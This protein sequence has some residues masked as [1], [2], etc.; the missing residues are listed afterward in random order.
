MNEHTA[1]GIAQIV[2]YVPAVVYI[3]YIGIRCWKYG[4]KMVW[5]PVMAFALGESKIYPASAPVHWQ[6]LTF[7]SQ[8]G[9]PVEAS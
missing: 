8:Y 6:W 3:F 2:F 5:Y 1:A 9:S 7:E 4:P